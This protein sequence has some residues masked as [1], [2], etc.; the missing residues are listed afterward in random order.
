MSDPPVSDLSPQRPTARVLA[1]L[2]FVASVL[3]LWQVASSYGEFLIPQQGINFVPERELA[4]YGYYGLCGTLALVCMTRLLTGVRWLERLSESLRAL[5]EQPGRLCLVLSLATFAA[6]LLFRRLVLEGQP[7]ADDE[8]TYLFIARTLLQGR[9]VNPPPPDPDFFR[10]QFIVL[11]EHGWYG[12]YPIGHPL[13]LAIFE[14]M[15]LRDIALPLMAAGSV[16]LCYALGAR[17]FGAGRAL[18][19]CALLVFSPHFIWT[20]GTLLSQTTGGFCLLL[21]SYGAM[22]AHETGHVRTAAL[23]GL[24]FGFGV[25]VRP[26]PG[27]LFAACACVWAL[28]WMRDAAPGERPRALLRVLA[29]CAT[30][31][32]GGLAVLCVNYA[33]TGDPFSSGY[34]EVHGHMAVMTNRQAELP[35]SVF[36]A[37]L[38]ENF[39]LLGVPGCLLPALAARPARFSWLFWSPFLAQLAYRMLY[40]KTVVGSTGPI[41]IT[42][43]VP[44]FTLAVVDGVQRLRRALPLRAAPLCAAV[45]L[46]A[47]C[48]FIPVQ[49]RTLRRAVEVR[50]LVFRMLEQSHAERALVFCD[51]LVF[52]SSGHSWAYFPDNPSPDLDDDVIFVRIPRAN[53][54][55][56]IQDFWRRRFPD[57]RAFVYTW[58]QQGE[59][60]FRELSRDAAQ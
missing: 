60:Q 44:L 57:R 36:G 2:G 43:L 52:P 15:R 49:F 10:N 20:A 51:A 50:S 30:T 5:G 17:W 41:Y 40:P 21:G 9:L 4:F 6:S 34:H 39:W 16:P 25:L 55:L 58:N 48:M 35:Q 7:V 54:V 22:R 38:R 11:G 45:V 53:V 1:A 8:G 19:A 37:L 27:V 28:S 18:A 26:L 56:N 23:A 59:P 42:E 13:L 3:G 24:A 12:K 14:A 32:L 29:L 46:T 31:A 47:A 33:Q